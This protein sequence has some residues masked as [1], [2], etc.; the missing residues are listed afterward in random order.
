MLNVTLIPCYSDNYAY[1]LST[2][3]SDEV[4]L[5]DGCEAAPIVAALGGRRLTA[6]LATHHHPDHVGGNL[7]LL[8][9]TL[10][11]GRVWSA[12]FIPAG[13][14]VIAWLALPALAIRCSGPAVVACS[15]ARRCSYTP[16]SRDWRSYHHRRRSIAVMSIWRATCS[17]PVRLSP[18]T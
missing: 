14:R 9:G 12:I 3:G 4:A 10:L 16:R 8:F 1:L 5:V 7:E 17:S 13:G 6:I 15:R 18:P 11:E 2:P